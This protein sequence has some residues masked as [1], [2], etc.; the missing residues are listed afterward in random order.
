MYDVD[1]NVLR[2]DNNR[3][4]TESIKEINEC[5]THSLMFATH[6]NPKMSIIKFYELFKIDFSCSIA[7]IVY[8]W[9]REKE[10]EIGNYYRNVKC[11]LNT[12]YKNFN[13]E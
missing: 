5:P 1:I 6:D 11:F 2:L 8:G 9:R 3:K 7:R 12:D 4:K 10:R 13:C